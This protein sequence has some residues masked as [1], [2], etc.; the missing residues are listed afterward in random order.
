[1]FPL[2]QREAPGRD[3]LTPE[4]VSGA[5]P[6]CAPDFEKDRKP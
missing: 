4:P 6:P 2:R 5:G 1:M 3:R